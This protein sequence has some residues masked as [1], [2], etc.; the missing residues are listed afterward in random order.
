MNFEDELID[1]SATSFAKFLLP[2]LKPDDRVLD[3][4]CGSGSIA[5]GL[6]D[7]VGSGEVIAVDVEASEFGPAIRYLG[8]HST[9]HVRFLAADGAAL[10]FTEAVFDAVL[11]H[12][13]LEVLPDPLKALDEIVR[14][15]VPGGVFGAASVD[16]G[17][18]LVAGPERPLLA[19][20]Y[21]AR[22][23]LWSVESIARPRA[24][25][26]LRGLF[27]A[28]GLTDIEAGARYVSYGDGAAI[29]SFGLA[30]AAECVD[31][32][33]SSRVT[34]LGLTTVAN[35]KK[36]ERAWRSWSES[37]DAFLAFPWCHAIGRKPLID[38]P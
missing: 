17:G 23:R 14:V 26:D 28:A 13:V 9:D 31:P 25:R 15:L 33:F 22:E 1:R 36:T 24:G 8:D 37:G 10:P 38:R 11:C 12:S 2:H 19:G 21:E 6:G 5:V 20:F 35:L 3:F 16:Y 32:W 34:D 7:V 27:H 18:L 30:R 29:R 4:G